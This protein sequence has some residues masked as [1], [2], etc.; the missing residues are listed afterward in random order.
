MSNLSVP[1]RK[2]E[3]FYIKI[4]NLLNKPDLDNHS[5]ALANILM[6]N[7]HILNGDA[8]RAREF[9]SVA[10]PLVQNVDTPSLEHQYQYVNIFV[11]RSEGDL[12]QALTTSENLYEEVKDIWGMNKLGDLILERAYISSLLSL[13]KEAIT[14]LDLALDYALESDDPYLISETYNVFGILYNFLNDNQS[15]IMY[16]E[17]A[18]EVME[19]HPALVSNIY[20]YA[21]LGDAY[22]TNK[23]YEKALELTHKARLLSIQEN[24]VPLQAFTHQVEARIDT[25]TEQYQAAIEQLEKAKALQEKVGEK[26]F[27]YELQTDFAYAYLKLGELDKAEQ[28]IEYAIEE[29]AKVAA[30]DDFYLKKLRAEISAQRGEFEMAFEL[31]DESFSVY[32]DTF[33]D[34]LTYVSNLSREQLDQERL[35]FENKLLEKENQISTKFVEQYKEYSTWLITLII[36]LLVLLLICCWLLIRYRRLARTN[37][38]MALTDN[39]T[40]LPNRRQVFRKLDNEHQRST[41]NKSVYSLII[42]DVDHFKTIND[43]FGHHVGDKVINRLARITRHILRDNDTIGRIS[44]EEFLIILPD[45]VM[46]DATQIATRLNE[47]FANAD[48]ED[49]AEGIHLTAS[50][51]VTEYTPE[52]EHLDMVIN[53]ADH[54][55]YKAKKEGR[56]RV[57]STSRDDSSED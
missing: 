3:A 39:L 40:L 6:A 27:G 52:D 15:A 35:S 29:A 11:L 4:N 17:K 32:R 13:Y 26:L 34:N 14:L 53:R 33:N 8:I 7:Y 42:F 16:F 44:G 45:T 49:L 43:R 2:Q 46:D 18:V 1:E 48:F 50:F 30:L 56:N 55:L 10:Q 36:L 37:Q 31:L 12:E 5:E 9:L 24:D 38:E 51:G 54:L 20:F 21:N 25:D 28:H 23:Q 22:R 41:L 47:Q 57:V 19:K